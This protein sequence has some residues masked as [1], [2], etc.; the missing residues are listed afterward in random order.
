MPGSERGLAAPGFRASQSDMSSK[1]GP[2][3]DAAT[4]TDI[5]RW[6]ANIRQAHRMFGHHRD[7]REPEEPP[8]QI[9]AETSDAELEGELADL[10]REIDDI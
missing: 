1:T 2:R 7:D 10:E 4:Q 6:I 3:A 9:G 8:K 5:R